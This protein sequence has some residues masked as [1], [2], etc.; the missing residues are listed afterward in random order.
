MFCSTCFMDWSG[1]TIV[2]IF[3][4]L[5]QW[6]P[7]HAIGVPTK[8]FK[9]SVGSSTPFLLKCLLYKKVEQD[10]LC[11]DLIFTNL[12]SAVTSPMK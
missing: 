5:C 12:L 11:T 8:C 10:A 1:Y 3:A 4:F 2:A 9:S 7:L 6:V